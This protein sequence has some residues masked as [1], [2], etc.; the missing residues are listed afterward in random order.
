MDAAI[1]VQMVLTL[2]EPQSSGIGGGAFLVHFDGNVVRTFDGRET[3]PTDVDESL[4]LGTDGKPLNF[5]D[6]AA[7]GRSVGT[8]G[9]LRML[10]LAHKNYGRLPWPMLFDSAINLAQ[11]GF[12]VSERLHALLA[13]ETRLKNDLFAFDYFYRRDGSP[14][15]IGTVIKNPTLAATLRK[16]ANQGADAFY[17]GDIARDIV[18]KVRAHPTHPG[19]LNVIDLADYR[20][21]ERAPVCFLYRHYD[22]CGMPPPASG[23]IAIGEILGALEYTDIAHRKPTRTAT[24]WR[25][26]PQ[27]VHLYSEA[28][29]LAYADRALYIADPDFV[30]LP[31][32]LLDKNY[33]LNRSRLIGETSMGKATP[34]VPPGEISSFAEDRSP[35]FPATSH[36]SVVDAFGNSVS[37]T[38]SIEDVF[39]SRL[40]VRG[41]ILN[42][43]LT[44][45]SFVASDN[46]RQVANRVQPGKRP[47]SSMSPTLVLRNKQL[48]M[49]IGSPGGSSIINYVAKVLI[50]TLD[51]GLN[52]QDAIS[53]P[54]FGSRNGPTELEK[55]R[56]DGALTDALTLRGHDVR[57][58]DQSSGLQGVM[59]Q[60]DGWFGGADPRREGVAK[61]E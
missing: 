17:K 59:R 53:L 7:S 58:I 47:R 44:D 61:G 40:M 57:L 6:A 38:T 32:T 55:G 16:I 25:L 24:G 19:R 54:N 26:D 11:T 35:E 4:F 33:L 21:K 60:G 13:K 20:A 28:A 41:F 34:G 10:E 29:R 36:I 27:A 51:W 39:G 50:G 43:Q 37:M 30:R 15:P 46:G 1:A 23:A 9:V 5:I 52:V 48:V 45:F 8:P 18:D 42:N 31:T 56:V 12:A 2:V 14:K 3:A 49:T 22:V